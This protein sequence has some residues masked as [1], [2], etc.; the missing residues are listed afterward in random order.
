MHVNS[1]QANLGIDSYRMKVTRLNQ[2]IT[3]YAV[4]GI[5]LFI[6]S[7]HQAPNSNSQADGA[8]PKELQPL[9]L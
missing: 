6:G 7:T 3:E 9:V 1:G 2:H 8:P 4:P 5:G